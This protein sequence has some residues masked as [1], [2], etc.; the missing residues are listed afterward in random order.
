MRRGGSG[1]LLL[2]E[3]CGYRPTGNTVLVKFT[4]N[5]SIQLLPT[6]QQTHSINTT[7]GLAVMFNRELVLSLYNTVK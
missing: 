5:K 2:L 3:I 6:S 7:G 1:F 4:Q